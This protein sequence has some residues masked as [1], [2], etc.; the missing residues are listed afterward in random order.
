MTRRDDW[1][2]DERRAGPVSRISRGLAIEF[3]NRRQKP[4]PYAEAIAYCLA[5][6]VADGR[7]LSDRLLGWHHRLIS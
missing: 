1:F 5:M 7:L 2:R 6:R 4:S 3:L